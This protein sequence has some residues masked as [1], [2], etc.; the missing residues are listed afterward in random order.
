MRFEY[1]FLHVTIQQYLPKIFSFLWGWFSYICQKLG[2]CSF[3]NLKIWPLLYSIYLWVCFFPHTILFLMLWLCMIGWNQ[4]C[5]FSYSI[6]S[7]LT[8]LGVS[9]CHIKFKFFF[10]LC[11]WRRSLGSWLGLHQICR[12]RRKAIFTILIFLIYEHGSFFHL[13]VSS[14]CF[15]SVLI[16]LF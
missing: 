3:M 11:L 12:F 7:A 10:L 2:C 5:W 15:L 6:L 14:I 8:I 9:C 16:S 1:Q 4:L 13:L